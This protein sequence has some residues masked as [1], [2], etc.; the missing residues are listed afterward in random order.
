MF[1]FAPLAALLACATVP[2][3]PPEA[4]VVEQ[5][6][7]AIRTIAGIPTDIPD[8]AERVVKSVVSVKVDKPLTL[9]AMGMPFDDEEL[10]RMFPG[11]RG[12]QRPPRNA[13]GMGSGVIV[14]VSGLVVT[15]NHVVDGASSITV[16]LPDGEALSATLVGTDPLTDVAV[17]RID[18]PP[19]NLVA[20]PFGDS[21]SLRLGE[22]VLAVGNPFGVG[23]TV[24]MGI[25]SATGR[26]DL[27]I[28]DYEDF[29]QTDAAINPGNSGGAL[30]DMRGQ[31][32]GIPTA[33]YSRTGGSNGIGFAIPAAMARTV[34]DDL[35][36]D[37]RVSRGWLGVGIQDLDN[38]LAKLLQAD[39]GAGV[40]FNQVQD[41][42]PAEKAG[43][44]TGDV[45]LKFNGEGVSD[46]ETFRRVVAGAGPGTKFTLELVRD[47]KPK[48]LTGT[49]VERPSA[50]QEV[51]SGSPLP[52]E[53]SDQEIG[54]VLRPLD[55][56]MRAQLGLSDRVSNGV[57]IARVVDESPAGR[58]GLKPG[59]VILEINRVEVATPAA[60]AAQFQKAAERALVLVS[61]EGA[62]LFRVVER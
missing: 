57:L 25:V 11:L 49:L 27:G 60:A 56:V 61:R 20:L 18:T 37:G 31:L 55:D 54:V 45:V 13:E 48:T 53:P 32:V 33:I 8:I 9:S 30:V 35:L 36:D 39:V 15:N 58:A 42:S 44:E 23:Q 24:T 38:D 4:V 62:T 17:I 3:P 6:K 52:D 7:V 28:V 29:I 41:G 34:V 51:A 12:P 46:A 21:E 50:D 10:G 14:D 40:V 19:K 59:D 26:N 43:V 47:G 5:T 2:P 22:L 1:R 16:L